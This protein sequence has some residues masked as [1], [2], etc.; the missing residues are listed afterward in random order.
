MDTVGIEVPNVRRRIDRRFA[1]A[2]V[3][4]S[5]VAALGVGYAI[6]NVSDAPAQPATVIARGTPATWQNAVDEANAVKRHT[7]TAART[8]LDIR[9][10]RIEE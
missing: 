7:A 4:G 3:A 2:I 5:A 10:A 8:P 1:G 6:G 9:I